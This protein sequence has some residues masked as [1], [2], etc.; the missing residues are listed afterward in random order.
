LHHAVVERWSRGHSLIHNRDPRVKLLALLVFLV[1]LATTEKALPLAGACYALLVAGAILLARLPLG[2]V[3]IRSSLVLPF[4]GTFALIT[5]LSG[6]THR[7]LALL[8]KSYLSAF[9]VL[10]LVGTTPLPVLLGGLESLGVP[11]F[12]VLVVQFLYRYLFVISE[13]AQH[14]RMAA[15]C[16]APV[17]HRIGRNRSRFRAAAGALAVLF[18]RSYARAEGI[19]QSMMSRGFDGHFRVLSAPRLRWTDAVFLLVAVALPCA[20]R[21]A[22]GVNA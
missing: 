9:A 5:L 12:L 10:L 1:V 19:H 22:T 15:A 11:N 14:M 7:A 17:R 4:S 6:D 18:A 21:Y 8:E 20:V 13:Q 2:G 3:L 16:R